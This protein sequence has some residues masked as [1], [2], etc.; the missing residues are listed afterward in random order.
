MLRMTGYIE[1]G[2]QG[3]DCRALNKVTKA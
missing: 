2:D 1:E 3:V